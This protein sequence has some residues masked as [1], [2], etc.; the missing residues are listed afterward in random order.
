MTISHNPH[1][2]SR[3]YI[4]FLGIVC[5]IAL[6]PFL[7]LTDFNTK[8]EPREAVVAYSILEQDNWILPTNNGGE[9]PYKPPLLHWLIAAMSV[10]FNCGVVSEYTSRLPSALAL[11]AMVIATYRFFAR[12]YNASVA[13]LTGLVTLT[14]FEIYRAGMNCRVD[15][16][17]TSLTVCAIYAL[18][19]WWE[20]GMRRLPWAAILLMSA[21][22]LTK[23]P[24]G[25]IIPCLVTGIFLLIKGVSFLRAFLWLTLWG[26]I[27]LILPLCWY[28]AAYHQGG[29]E[30]LDLVLEE[31]FGR[32]TGTMAYE[33]H[34]NPWY[35]NIATLSAGFLPWTLLLPVALCLVRRSTYARIFRIGTGYWQRFCNHIRQASPV[36]VLAAVAA[37]TIFIFYCIPASKRSVY[38]MPMYPFTALFIARILVWLSRR[39]VTVLRV[40]AY[41]ISALGIL[42]LLIFVSVKC[43]W[44]GDNLFGHGKHAM[45]NAAMLRSLRNVGVFGWICAILPVLSAA[46][47]WGVYRRKT[48]AAHLPVTLSLLVVSLYISLSGCYLPGVLN[49]K[50]LKPMSHEM[51]SLYPAMPAQI[52]EFMSMAEE[53]KGNPMHFFEINYYLGDCV[54][55]FRKERPEE[56]YLLITAADAEEYLSRF[57]AE[58]YRFRTVYVPLP[59]LPRHTPTLYHFHK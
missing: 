42:L 37:I 48:V 35:Y 2:D 19:R 3:K 11:I 52:Y 57:E 27:S 7:G 56:G 28:V 9:I 8:G 47:W 18:F 55:N 4:V 36:S 30:F 15:M 10:I 21:A 58:G 44:I 34:L 16:L 49:A 43:G 51:Q 5:C 40:S 29:Q 53:A 46:W 33:S 50:S 23:G 6:L 13:L 25:I 45:Q 38:L 24:V 32:M 31:N 54:R 17:L 39:H 12:R 1:T 59:T 22:T 26:V 41:V 14:A 20:T